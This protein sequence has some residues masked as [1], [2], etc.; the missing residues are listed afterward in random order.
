MRKA[1]G[2]PRLKEIRLLRD[3]VE[4]AQWKEY[5]FNVPVICSL[6]SM[7]LRSR[8]VFFVGENGSGKSTLLEAIADHCGYGREGGSKNLK[9]QTA[10][11]Q[12][13]TSARL[14]RVLRLSWSQKL[15]RG[16]FLRA[17]SFFNL[18]TH[19]DNDAESGDDNFFS[20]PIVMAYG[21]K[22]LHEQSHGQSFFALFENRFAYKGFYL[23]DEPEAALSPQRQ[24]SLLLLLRRYLKKD[25]E[26][27][28]IIATHSPLLLAFPGAQ[29]FSFDGPKITELKY[30]QTEPFQLVSGFLRDPKLYMKKLFEEDEPQ[31][32]LDL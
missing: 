32:E 17:E 6:E 7:E 25:P 11:A 31:T 3:R 28:F 27:Q 15:L 29:I 1:D 30:E 21:G 26:T 4:E 13:A 20:P 14:A 16:Y 22:S 9:V 23:M 19:I 18:A 8:V 24:L 12:N 2:G 5:P 10:A